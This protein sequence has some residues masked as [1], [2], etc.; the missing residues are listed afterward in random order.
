V[1]RFQGFTKYGEKCDAATINLMLCELHGEKDF[2]ASAKRFVIIA[3]ANQNFY[4]E[5]FNCN[6]N[7]MDCYHNNYSCHRN[8]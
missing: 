1:E 4:G 3:S 8:K 5:N 6:N 2:I 7:N